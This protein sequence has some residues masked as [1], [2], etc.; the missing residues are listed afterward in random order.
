VGADRVAVFVCPADRPVT[1][2]SLRRLAHQFLVRHVYADADTHFGTAT[3]G[4]YQYYT[5]SDWLLPPPADP[6]RPAAFTACPYCQGT[7][8]GRLPADCPVC[9]G[10]PWR[11]DWEFG[12]C[13]PVAWVRRAVAAG[14][15][16]RPPNAVLLPDG[17]V[18]GPHWFARALA[19]F[20][21]G[22]VVPVAAG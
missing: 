8:A 22:W 11:A 16:E 4:R 7:G 14:Q 20:P 15:V 6:D 5:P 19:E 21:D 10:R 3:R 13:Y 17:R 18:Y 12:G 1:P 2:D 9:D